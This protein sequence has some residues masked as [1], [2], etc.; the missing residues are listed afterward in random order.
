MATTLQFKN[1]QF[2]NS[3]VNCCRVIIQVGLPCGMMP[4]HMVQTAIYWES[5]EICLMVVQTHP[6]HVYIYIH[7]FI[8][9]FIYNHIY[10]YM[11][12][13]I[14][15][16]MCIYIYTCVYIYINIRHNSYCIIY[17]GGWTSSYTFQNMAWTPFTRH[18][19]PSAARRSWSQHLVVIVR[20]DLRHLGSADQ[21][22]TVFL[23]LDLA[24]GR[25]L[26]CL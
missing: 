24:P 17:S 10:I 9:I 3:A 12:I 14:Y 19:P 23:K 6:N 8:S 4:C 5:T 25:R 7:I 16:Y 2:G 21:T 13:Y 15:I 20:K 18:G 22:R 11:Y 26:W 1:R